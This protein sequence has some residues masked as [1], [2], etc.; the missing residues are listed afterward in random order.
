MN[1]LGRPRNGRCCQRC[2]VMI[3]KNRPDG[4]LWYVCP[5]HGRWQ[6]DYTGD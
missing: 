4:P 2:Q 6:S 1:I 5:D 3:D